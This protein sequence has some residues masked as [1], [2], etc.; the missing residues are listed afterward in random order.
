MELPDT[1]SSKVPSGDPEQWAPE[2]SDD[3]V[4]AA[5]TTWDITSLLLG[6]LYGPHVV[7]VHTG[8]ALRAA[9]A[10]FIGIFRLPPPVA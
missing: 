2:D 5:S 7:D 8:A 6:L 1:A 4:S 3:A 10:R 9:Q